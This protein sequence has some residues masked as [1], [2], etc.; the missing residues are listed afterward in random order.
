MEGE[1]LEESRERSVLNAQGGAHR[2][3]LGVGEMPRRA[4]LYRLSR[5]EERT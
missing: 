5:E 4:V 2:K 1:D 3:G